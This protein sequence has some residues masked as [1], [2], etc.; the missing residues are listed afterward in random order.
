MSSASKHINRIDFI[1]N[2]YNDYGVIIDTHTADGVKAA[3]DHSVPIYPMI[4]L[5]TALPVKFEKSVFEAIGVYPKRPD[6]L[7][8]LRIT[9]SKV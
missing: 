3:I 9:R 6:A 2:I 5:E 7:K 1:R 8:D 4:V